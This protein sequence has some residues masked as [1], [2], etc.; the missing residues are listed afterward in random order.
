[1]EEQTAIE[2]PQEDAEDD[3][4]YGPGMLVRGMYERGA[5]VREIALLLGVGKDRVHRAL[6]AVNT[7]L[8]R[9]GPRGSFSRKLTARDVRQIRARLEAGERQSAVARDVGVSRQTIHKIKSGQIWKDK[10]GQK[11]QQKDNP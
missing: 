9:P 7:E 8:R 6:V 2:E 3:S 1:M 4:E 11:C 5:T 10:G